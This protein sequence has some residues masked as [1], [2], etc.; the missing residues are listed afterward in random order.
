MPEEQPL[1]FFTCS[2]ICSRTENRWAVTGIS[3]LFF[4]DEETAR[5]SVFDLR[6]DLKTDPDA[7]WVAM[8][9]EKIEILPMT[10][11]N[12][13]MLLNEGISAIVKHYQIVGIE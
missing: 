9:I 3:D 13:M 5:Q 7:E 8:R 4:P 1:T 12:V 11:E 6:K 10:K 2:P